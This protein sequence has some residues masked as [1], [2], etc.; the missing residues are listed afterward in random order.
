MNIYNGAN[1]GIRDQNEDGNQDHQIHE[2]FLQ[3]TPRPRDVTFTVPERQ[4][5]S[6]DSFSIHN[7]NFLKEFVYVTWAAARN[8][9]RQQLY[10]PNL[11]LQPNPRPPVW[12]EEARAMMVLWI[13]RER[14]IFEM[15]MRELEYLLGLRGAR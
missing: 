5:V 7:S 10:N 9:V 12:S 11:P 3:L 14:R 6:N 4:I 2:H 1:E 13:A 15:E 8:R